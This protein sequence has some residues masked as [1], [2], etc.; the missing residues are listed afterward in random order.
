MLLSKV[1]SIWIVMLILCPIHSHY[2]QLADPESPPKAYSQQDGAKFYKRFPIQDKVV[3]A[4]SAFIILII[5]MAR[6]VRVL[7][8]VWVVNGD[9]VWS[10]LALSGLVLKDRLDYLVSGWQKLCGGTGGPRRKVW[11]WTKILSPNI[12]YSAAN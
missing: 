11:T 9:M 1:L 3:S 2:N 7:R 12:C 4:D 8:M 10:I 5:K 6:L